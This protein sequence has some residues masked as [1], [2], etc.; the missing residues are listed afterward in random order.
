MKVLRR[1]KGR[2]DER[3]ARG[4]GDEGEARRVR[5]F[6]TFSTLLAHALPARQSLESKL[7]SWEELSHPNV[8]PFY[9]VY[10]SQTVTL[11]V[12]IVV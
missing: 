9:G 10:V 12:L 4:V 2:G 7:P 5:F 3:G 1:R 6:L 8:L 11:W